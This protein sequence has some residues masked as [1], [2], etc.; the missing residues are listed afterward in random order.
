M[1]VSVGNDWDGSSLH[2]A[3]SQPIGLVAALP[4]HSQSFGLSV[5]V[6]RLSGGIRGLLMVVE[7]VAT[8]IL[9]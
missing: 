7:H 8:L 1:V 3:S 5:I 4:P 2:R 9:N 6:I